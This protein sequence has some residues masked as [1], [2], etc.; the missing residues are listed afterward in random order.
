M[1]RTTLLATFSLVSLVLTSCG[2]SGGGSDE[3]APV[4]T[5]RWGQ[6]GC[7]TLKEGVTFRLNYSLANEPMGSDDLTITGD[8]AD[9]TNCAKEGLTVSE[10]GCYD[11]APGQFTLKVSM[12]DGAG[13][14]ARYWKGEVVKGTFTGRTSVTHADG[15]SQ[16]YEFTGRVLN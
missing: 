5:V 14:A 3:L 11:S 15:T 12:S 2:G 16:E 1:M 9:C 8:K 7:G 6:A 4:D 10:T 13:G